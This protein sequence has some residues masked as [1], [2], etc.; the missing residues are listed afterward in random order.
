MRQRSK[1]CLIKQHMKI[2]IIGIYV[3]FQLKI[4]DIQKSHSTDCEDPNKEVVFVLKTLKH[5]ATKMCL[6]VF[7][8]IATKSMHMYDLHQCQLCPCC[9]EK[10]N[11]KRECKC[12]WKGSERL[13]FFY[14]AMCLLMTAELPLLTDTFLRWS[15]VV[16][17]TDLRLMT[18]AQ[19]ISSL[20]S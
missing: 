17:G 11:L 14:P 8:V 3:V 15:L 4:T 2:K 20:V 16:H 10:S 19:V 13:P 1:Y 9:N 18:C 5:C 7:A 6:K 12:S